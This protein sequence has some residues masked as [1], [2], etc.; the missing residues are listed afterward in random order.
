[1][2]TNE[3]A[4]IASLV[5][6]PVRT[7]MLLA[8]MDGRAFTAHELARVGG[9]TPQT[10]SGHLAQLVDAGLLAVVKQGRHRY[11]RLASPEVAAMLESIMQVA[12]LERADTPTITT[13]PS[14]N[15]MRKARLCYDHIGGRLGVAITDYLVE[16]QA[17]MLER[18]SARITNRLQSVLE[19]I[20]LM[21]DSA[22]PTHGDIVCRPC[23]DWS[24]RRFHLAGPLGR[25][26]CSHLISRGI[27][28]RSTGSRM[29]TITGKGATELHRWLGTDT[30]SRV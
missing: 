2:N 20:N 8:L 5:G 29:L 24:E 25:S 17:I 18:D 19:P 21:F 4:R 27:L 28:R 6:M 30:W 7:A 16:Q 12:A 13:G 1:M 15:A 9:I 3:I 10:A 26:L 22:S 11:H 23:L 14:D